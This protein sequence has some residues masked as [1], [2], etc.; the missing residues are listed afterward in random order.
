MTLNSFHLNKYKMENDN[1][2]MNENSVQEN[3]Y[4]A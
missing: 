3:H 1:S 4:E 2:N